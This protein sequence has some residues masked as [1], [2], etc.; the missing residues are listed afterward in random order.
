MHVRYQSGSSGKGVWHVVTQDRAGGT[1]PP[2]STDGEITVDSLSTTTL[3][4]LLDTADREGEAY[5]EA[6]LEAALEVAETYLA[7]HRIRLAARPAVEYDPWQSGVAYDPYHGETEGLVIGGPRGVLQGGY[8]T[9]KDHGF[10]DHTSLLNV[11]TKGL[12]HSYH[13]HLVDEHFDRHAGSRTPA[14]AAGI[15]LYDEYRMLVPAVDE[16]FAQLF[17]LY[18]DGD[19]TDA[20]L[21]EAYVDA[22]AEWY[23]DLTEMDVGLFRAVAETVSAQAGGADGDA[24]DAILRGLR[25]QEPLI[26]NADVSVISGRLE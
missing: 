10:I 1:G 26:R 5:V 11:L 3:G 22:W 9:L 4:D 23:R 18:V 13:Q 7:E 14:D 19:V 12:M 2:V 24:K 6:F 25:I 16:G 21:R 15:T 8:Q 17:S 20:D